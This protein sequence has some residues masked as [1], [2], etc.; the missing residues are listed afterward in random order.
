MVQ[1]LAPLGKIGLRETYDAVSQHLSG[2]IQSAVRLL[3][4]QGTRLSLAPLRFSSSTPRAPQ[5]TNTYEIG[6]YT[7]HSDL[8]L[9]A[10]SPGHRYDF[11][12]KWGKEDAPFQDIHIVAAPRSQLTKR[13]YEDVI[14]GREK[15]LGYGADGV[16]E[17]NLE[18]AESSTIFMVYEKARLPWGERLVKNLTGYTFDRKGDFRKF[19]GQARLVFNHGPGLP[20]LQKDAGQNFSEQLGIW[21][22][23][24]VATGV[25]SARVD[26]N[27]ISAVTSEGNGAGTLA[28]FLCFQ[29]SHNANPNAVI[30]THNT[31]ANISPMATGGRAAGFN[32]L[33]NFQYLTNLDR[34]K[35][36]NRMGQLR[37]PQDNGAPLQLRYCAFKHG[38]VDD[39]MRR[40]A[41]QPVLHT[42]G[43]TL[44]DEA[45]LA[46]LNAVPEYK[47]MSAMFIPNGKKHPRTPVEP[48]LIFPP[49][50]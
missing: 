49:L 9:Q 6:K 22:K 42:N 14:A 19:Q 34:T 21:S 31:L 35:M 2:L 48:W 27:E 11:K 36:L 38:S 13:E 5:P 15:W 50:G 40:M 28:Q 3:S 4:G 32:G 41:E 7:L 12:A 16:D 37:F 23:N 26:I 43:Y 1:V 46:G 18:M 29:L 45:S 30:L 20:T 17:F 8:N 44:G 47:V 33:I 39:W 24:E 25:Q 10:L